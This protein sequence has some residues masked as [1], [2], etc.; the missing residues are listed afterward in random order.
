M[1]K[2]APSVGRLAIAIGFALSCFGLLL[3]LWVAFGGPVPL[4]SKSYRV[5]AYF[6]EAIQ[7]AVESDVRIGGVSVGSVKAVDLAPADVRIGGQDV[8]SAELEIRPEFAPISD[9]ARAMLRQKTLLGETYVELTSGTKP[10]DGGAP[11]S[12]GAAANN[13]DA[14]VRRVEA[15]PE[16]GT[17]PAGQTQD[18]VLIDEIFNALDEE[19]RGSFQRWMQ[20]SAV[21]VQGRGLDLND[22][23]GNLGPF[24]DD[25]SNVLAILERQKESL[26]GLVRDTGTVFDALSERDDALTGL[27]TNSNETFDAL[28]S[29]EE[30]L[31]EIFQVLPTFQRETRTTLNRLD[32][33]QENTLP[34]V[35]D[36]QPVADD[37]TPTLRSVRRLSPNLTRLFPD[38]DALIRAS[39]RGFPALSRTLRELRPVMDSLNPFLAELNPV[40]DFLEYYKFHINDFLSNP[41]VGISGTL[42]PE[43]NQPAARFSLRQLGYITQE[44]LSFYPQRLSTNRGNGYLRP[45]NDLLSEREMPAR[46]I[47]P[48][49]DC[50][51][52]DGERDFGDGGDPPVGVNFAPC[53]VDRGFP[54]RF[55]GDLIPKV[56]RDGTP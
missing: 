31:A 28:A 3:F 41:P 30:A 14:E 32:A 21:A 42:A 15:L 1:Q 9:D 56:R 51:P 22:A 35:L 8:T 5:N 55:G 29:E 46:G 37:A 34:L 4:K 38:I 43:P 53:F 50:R 17:L 20:N 45:F 36:L 16:G 2:S 26:K 23:F 19:T 6:P 10:R 24:L 18:Q 47:F 40:V 13:S 33:F 7:L 54:Q 25:A 12:L 44:S 27:I 49:I 39:R 11:V 52:S 48:N